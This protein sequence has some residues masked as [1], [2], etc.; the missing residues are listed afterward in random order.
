MG[1]RRLAALLVLSL[2]A[3]LSAAASEGRPDFTAM[4]V[5]ELQVCV[6]LCT[7]SVRGQA[8]AAALTRGVGCP[9]ALLSERGV[10]CDGCA[11]KKDLIARVE[12][13]YDMP[14]VTAQPV[15]LVRR[16]GSSPEVAHT[17][18]PP[19]LFAGGF[20]TQRGGAQ[21]QSKDQGRRS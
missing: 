10:K 14:V 7:R 1:M 13:T 17:C 5:K 8:S 21:R 4:R 15:R 11:E 12:E 2:M 9:Q 3:V 19:S 6:C 20:G 16:I 18:P